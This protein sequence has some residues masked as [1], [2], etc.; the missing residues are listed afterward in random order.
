MALRL[1]VPRTEPP[2]SLMDRLLGSSVSPTPEELRWKGS[3]ILRI[4][5]CPREAIYDG[6]FGTRSRKPGF[7]FLIFLDPLERISLRDV[8]WAVSIVD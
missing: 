3:S 6:T 2:P 8:L 4:Q 7:A 5:D 1:A